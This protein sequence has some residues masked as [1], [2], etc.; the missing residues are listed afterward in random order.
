MHTPA[1]S[2]AVLA[3][4]AGCAGVQPCLDQ[5]PF[6]ASARAG[7][8]LTTFHTAAALDTCL[9]GYRWEG[10][11]PVRGT[12]VVVHGIRDHALRYSAL[13]EE[14]AA[15]GF[16]VYAQD[17]RGHGRSGG[18]RQRWDS[19]GQLA[20]DEGLL[21]EEAARQHPGV[22]RFVYGHSLGGLVATHVALAHPEL[23]GVVLSGAAL[24]LLPGVSGGQQAA[25]RFFGAVI[26]SLA[27]QEVD[28]SVFVR[29]PA[30]KAALAQDP[31]IVH[32]NLP[33]RSAAATLDGLEAAQARFGELAMP[34][35]V[36]HGTHDLATNVEGS[37]ALVA[38]A[39]STDKTL[40]L[41]E[42]VSHDLLH[43]PEAPQVIALVAGW[44]SAH[45]AP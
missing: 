26:P 12:V 44:L 3:L 38:K 17:L 16:A 37:K 21:L 4:L 24:Q 30:A 36:M 45:A 9:Q 6:P 29:E 2:L 43:E 14:L 31:L 11:G 1:R 28:D 32:A 41:W 20:G 13:A 10:P 25:A 35:L 18:P 23:E 33:A 7:V 27:A 19:L 8:T 40:H 42:G 15:Q 34:L 39:R 22:P 5:G